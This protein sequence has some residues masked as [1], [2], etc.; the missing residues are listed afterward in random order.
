MCRDPLTP[1]EWQHAVDAAH[2]LLVLD[3]ARKYGLII[4]GPVVNPDRADD[5]LAQGRA[6]GINP[7]PDAVDRL[8]AELSADRG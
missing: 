6:R 4:G 5:I 8:V 1:E 7:S 3:S 2:A